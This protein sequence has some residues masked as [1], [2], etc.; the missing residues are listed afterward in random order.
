MA[1]AD[2]M[3]NS[4]DWVSWTPRGALSPSFEIDPLGGPSERAALVVAGQ[5]NPHVCGCWQLPLPAFVSGRSYRIE[6]LFQTQGV[7][8]PGKSVRAILTTAQKGL[9]FYAH[10]DDAGQVG[11][12]HKLAFTFLV[13]DPAPE[14]MLHL[15]FAW[16]AFGQVSWAD[17]QVHEIV[18]S[19]DAPLVHVA[20]ISGNPTKPESPAQ[21]L[22]FYAKQIDALAQP[23]DLICLPELINVTRLPGS[24]ADWAEPI[25]GPTSELLAEKAREKGAYIA[26]SI[27]ERQEDAIFN[28]GFL[29]DRSGGLVGKYRK[30]HPTLSESLLRGV[31]PGNE[32]P[33]FYTDFGP[34]AYMICYDG[35]YPEV[36]R[37]LGLKGVQMILFSNMGDGREG[38]GLWESVVRTRAVDNQVYIVAA[39]NSGRSCVV[40]PKGE[41]LAMTD[42]TP[43]AVAQAGCDLSASLCDFSKRPIH[44]RYDQLRRA[45]LFED[46]ARH[47]WDD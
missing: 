47:L 18:E 24:G 28:T 41:L 34:I 13:P 1:F 37:L 19:E 5:G 16:S 36:A 10:L 6:V 35:H 45:D 9:S 20:A 3:L 23:V 15:F 25:P 17:A 38:G 26:A 14:L 29:L 33:V 4:Q 46:L 11:D 39:V 12:W 42:Q 7:T 40:D 8:S 22:D 31:V 43:G 27:Q 44:R 2:L 21:C 30:T 32:L